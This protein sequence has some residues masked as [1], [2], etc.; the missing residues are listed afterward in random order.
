M[1]PIQTRWVV[2]VTEIASLD[3]SQNVT[4]GMLE[5]CPRL[6]EHS[7]CGPDVM[8]T[9][10]FNKPKEKSI[11]AFMLDVAPRGPRCLAD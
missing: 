2:S 9:K 11:V 10:Y 8:N 7:S 1:V 6:H 5:K 3:A 4:T